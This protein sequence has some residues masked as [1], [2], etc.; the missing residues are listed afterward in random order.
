MW[1]AASPVPANSIGWGGHMNAHAVR[2][3]AVGA[4]AIGTIGGAVAMGSNGPRWKSFPSMPTERTAFGAVRLGD[5]RIL[6]IGG[7][8]RGAGGSRVKLAAVDVYDPVTQRWSAAAP[9]PAVQENE[10]AAV[11]A[12]GRVYAVG[13]YGM[14]NNKYLNTLNIYDPAT[15]AWTQGKSMPTARSYLTA[16]ALTDGRIVAIGGAVPFME[17]A[18][19]EAYTP[20][21]NRWRALAPLPDGCQSVAAATAP[22]GKVYVAGGA[23]NA[24]ATSDQLEIYDPAAN[25]WTP[26]PSL[27]TPIAFA[28]AAWG[29]D[30]RFYVVSGDAGGYAFDPG[31]GHWSAL[32]TYPLPVVQLQVV[33][34]L[35]GKSIIGLGGCGN[36]DA[37]CPTALAYKLVVKP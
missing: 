27:P 36:T 18:A 7:I 29:A 35:N 4:L 6:A 2:R 22:D 14:N 12:D 10:G 34:G 3:V 26:G 17:S 25:T 24:A 19:V 21:T 15:N 16:V 9:L 1:S 28:S 33:S 31:T 30:G 8:G 20:S 32:P 13:G 37:T 11:G 23:C 5:G